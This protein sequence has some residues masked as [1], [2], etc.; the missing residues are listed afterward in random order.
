MEVETSTKKD[1]P[2]YKLIWGE[3]DIEHYL[4]GLPEVDNIIGKVKDEYL[5]FQIF[6][7]PFPGVSEAF[8]LMPDGLGYY[9]YLGIKN[10]QLPARPTSEDYEKNDKI[11][12]E[13]LERTINETVLPIRI[14]NGD[15][16]PLDIGYVSME[17]KKN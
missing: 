3:G 4:S 9:I 6:P 5:F 16:N 7:K 10:P 12:Q 13:N 17:V 2:H 1:K 11:R 14:Y 15:N 8:E